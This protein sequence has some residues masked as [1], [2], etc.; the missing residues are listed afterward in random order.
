MRYLLDTN[1]CSYIQRGHPLVIA[2]L[3]QLPEDAEIGISV[4]TQ[5]EL[6]AGV[7]RAP[8]LRRRQELRTLYET[9]ISQVSIVYPIDSLIAECYAEIVEQLRLAGTPI[10][11]NDIWIAATARTLELTLVSADRHFQQI[12]NLVLE[13]WSV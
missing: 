13:N 4:I 12:P 6:L 10:P 1:H 9:I 2:R 7:L 3:S 8:N 11:T 5:G